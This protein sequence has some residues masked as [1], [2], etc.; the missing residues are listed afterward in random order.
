[1]IVYFNYMEH[2]VLY[3]YFIKDTNRYSCIPTLLLGKNDILSQNQYAHKMLANLLFHSLSKSVIIG[4]GDPWILLSWDK[5][6]DDDTIDDLDLW[7]VYDTVKDRWTDECLED[8]SADWLTFL[9]LTMDNMDRFIL[10]SWL[11]ETKLKSPRHIADVLSP[12]LA[13]RM[14]DLKRPIKLWNSAY[15]VIEGS[16][17]SLLA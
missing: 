17:S 3:L 15:N 7:F 13:D 16:R 2:T 6:N 1:M 9:H 11:Q 14:R 8:T 5:I 4:L 12:K 10:T